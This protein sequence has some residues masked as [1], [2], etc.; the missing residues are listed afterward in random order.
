MKRQRTGA[1][2]PS[3]GVPTVSTFDFDVAVQP[4]YIDFLNIGA[5]YGVLSV[6]IEGL[7]YG[8]VV[9]IVSISI[10]RAD[11]SGTP[12]QKSID[13]VQRSD[14]YFE[15][16]T[17]EKIDAHFT[18]TAAEI[19]VIAAHDDFGYSVSAQVT[20]NGDTES[21][22]VQAGNIQARTGTAPPPLIVATIDVT[23]TTNT[24]AIG[25][26]DQL[27][28]VAYD[29]LGDVV[30]G[31]VFAWSS[32]NTGIATVDDDGLVTYVGTGIATIRATAQGI[33]GH[34]TATGTTGATN[35]QVAGYLVSD[36]S[37]LP[38]SLDASW[39]GAGTFAGAMVFAVGLSVT[40]GGVTVSGGT[41][42]VQALTATTISG[43]GTGH[44]GGDFD[45]NTNKF[46]VN[47]TTGNTSVAG[48]LG[49]TGAVS[50][51]VALGVTNGG[52]G[53][54]SYTIGDTLYAGSSTTLAK[55][56]IGSS[57]QLLRST[58]SA[59]AWST[60]SFPVTA[61]A[62]DLMYG[63]ASNVWST[64]A[65]GS[66]NGILHV[67]AG[68]PSWT[69]TPSGLT[70][71]GATTGTFTSIGGTL[72]TVTQPNVTTMAA[73]VTVGV[74]ASPHMT[75][76][77]VDSGGITVTA[78]TSALQAV[79]AT[80][81]AT[82]ALYTATKTTGVQALFT[83]YAIATGAA[84]AGAGSI[85]I[86]AT[87]SDA[88]HLSYDDAANTVLYLDNTYNSNASEIR[89]RTKTQGNNNATT[90]VG[91][92][93]FGDGSAIANGAWSGFTT[94]TATTV[95]AALTG[96][97]T[98][99][100]ALQTARTINTVSFDGTANIIVTAAA[101]TLTGATLASGVTASSLTS[102]GILASPH[103]TTLTVDSGGLTITSG[104]LA[105]QAVTA[106]TIQA[107]GLGA[108][109]ASDKYVV[110]DSSGN[111]HK[112]ALGPIS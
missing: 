104:T 32:T 48:T 7:L 21:R 83:G 79:T 67:A 93:I 40:T 78:G 50:L 65:I 49:V 60:A 71:I 81:L 10:Q 24:G 94:L 2:H 103:V 38:R 41:T 90:V 23:P 58:G 77:V 36:D 84:T 42:A 4:T 22:E 70:S 107:T 31:V 33:V 17:Q 25:A 16:V 106:T 57:G 15:W 85:Q 97:A 55:L 18:L 28:A 75:G 112:S 108:F 45:V 105:A 11:G 64:L 59:P 86:G 82:N 14:G 46:T 61:V 43:S 100:T 109:V 63:S 96:N 6:P 26:T 76:A 35:K 5:G 69:L 30:P 72:T 47:A 13:M 8:D 89:F 29:G 52:T 74:L 99:A 1:R 20:R 39:I 111:F 88:G 27:T 101:G 87:L 66:T 19:A 3:R 91:L 51:T 73:L 44:V 92:R 102:V 98:T 56:G 34:A 95:I 54:A 12:I 37:W 62:G 68:L 53:F 9:E 110:V 80:T